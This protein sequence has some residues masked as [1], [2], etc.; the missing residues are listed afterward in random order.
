M[1]GIDAAV[2]A[3]IIADFASF[4]VFVAERYLASLARRREKAAAA[5]SDALLW[6][7]MP[8]RIARRTGDDTAALA[9]LTNTMHELQ[10]RH[11]FNRAW[12]QVE[13]PEAYD[14]YVSLIDDIRSQCGPNLT[15]A[16]Q[17]LPATKPADMNLGAIYLVD[18]QTK[19]D[20]YVQAVRAALRPW[21]IRP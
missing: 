13:V 20:A 2:L 10:E 18:V 15:A 14:A 16:W 21:K 4:V 9:A 5:L 11:L 6:I 1:S 19:I 7:E 17:R 12:I 3:A 8:Y